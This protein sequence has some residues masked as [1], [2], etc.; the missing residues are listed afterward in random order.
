MYHQRHDDDDGDGDGRSNRPRRATAAGALLLGAL[1]LAACGGDEDAEPD[2]SLEGQVRY[3]CALA[4]NAEE[5]H[6]DPMEW[7]I[8]IGEDA[9]PGWSQ[10]ASASSLLGGTTGFELAEYPQLSEAATG[11]VRAVSTIDIEQLSSSLGDIVTECENVPDG[12]DSD[13]SREG[14]TA[15]AC[16]LAGYIIEEHGDIDTWGGIGDEPAWHQTA[17][18][19]ALMG[20]MNAYVVDGEEEL[21]E[22]GQ[23]A[24]ESV[25]RM[26]TEM[27][28]ESLA[29]IAA[30][31]D[32]E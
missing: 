19:G 22:A 14:Q 13:V 3:A 8:A 26:D 29:T 28:Q 1:S 9:N 32:D 24:I 23:R 12:P 31:C 4:T 17:T 21:S 11:V 5:A 18:V 25:S 10:V 15:Y 20:G 6:G 7:D 27:M 16:A 30:G 2:V